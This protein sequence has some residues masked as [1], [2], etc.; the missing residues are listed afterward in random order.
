MN[1]E[2][3]IDENWNRTVQ[4]QEQEREQM[5]G[6]CRKRRSRKKE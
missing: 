1:Y 5:Y 3:F 6:K 4:E 2:Q